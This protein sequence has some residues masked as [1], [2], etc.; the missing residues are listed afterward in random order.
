MFNDM[1]GNAEQQLNNYGMMGTMIRRPLPMASGVSSAGRYLQ[2]MQR[3]SIANVPMASVM[4]AGKPG[5]GGMPTA[6]DYMMKE[7][8][9]GGVNPGQLPGVNAVD[10]MRQNPPPRMNFSPSQAALAGYM[11]R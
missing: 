1:T 4:R 11:N 9:S 7:R 5:M 6:A 2:P 3:S 8:M 10:Q